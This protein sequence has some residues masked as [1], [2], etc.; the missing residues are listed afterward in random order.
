MHERISA[1][2]NV[3]FLI[4]L[5]GH[6]L[7]GHSPHL[8]EVAVLALRHRG[9]P[10]RRVGPVHLAYQSA[11][12]C[13]SVARDRE[14]TGFI[15]RDLASEAAGVSRSGPSQALEPHAIRKLGS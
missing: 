12:V 14:Q 10:V 5:R 6:H 13:P 4:R 11:T 8:I 3:G 15:P 9:P 2:N 7:G 1:L